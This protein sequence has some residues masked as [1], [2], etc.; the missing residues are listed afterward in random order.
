MSKKHTTILTNPNQTSRTTS[1]LATCAVKQLN[2]QTNFQEESIVSLTTKLGI[3]TF[4]ARPCKF[5]N[6]K[7]QKKG[8]Y[9]AKVDS[10]FNFSDAKKMAPEDYVWTLNYKEKHPRPH[11]LSL[12]SIR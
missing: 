12:L 1:L 10:S 11:G 3:Y 6:T 8:L 4:R 2:H 9:A 5:N 7:R